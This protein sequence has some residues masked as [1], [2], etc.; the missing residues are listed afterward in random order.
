MA[1]FLRWAVFVLGPCQRGA[2][3]KSVFPVIGM[4]MYPLHLF[5]SFISPQRLGIFTFPLGLLVMA[6]IS[7][8]QTLSSRALVDFS[9]FDSVKV[10]RWPIFL[11]FSPGFCPV[12]GVR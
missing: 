12:A 6:L 10:C 11:F 8:L 2:F 7:F 4:Q 9:S 3:V 1:R 5:L